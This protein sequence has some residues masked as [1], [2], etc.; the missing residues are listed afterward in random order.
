MRAKRKL[1]CSAG[2]IDSALAPLEPFPTK[3]ISDRSRNILLNQDAQLQAGEHSIVRIRRVRGQPNVAAWPAMQQA[4]HAEM[5]AQPIRETAVV[6][7]LSQRF[8]IR[9]RNLDVSLPSQSDDIFP[10]DPQQVRAESL[11]GNELLKLS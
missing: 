1:I 2:M 6:E 9:D 10:K 5:D 7:G 3:P 4:E 11:C 8:V